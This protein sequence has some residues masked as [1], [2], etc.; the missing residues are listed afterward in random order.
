MAYHLLKS[1]K[2]LM[3]LTFKEAPDTTPHS[4]KA[5]TERWSQREDGILNVNLRRNHKKEPRIRTKCFVLYATEP[6]A[7][8]THATAVAHEANRM[9]HGKHLKQC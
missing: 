8:E 5:F 4:E 2:A 3:L 6:L 7:T 9:S 1:F